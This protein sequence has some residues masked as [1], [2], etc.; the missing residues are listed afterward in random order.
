VDS[1]RPKLGAIQTDD[2]RARRAVAESFVD[3]YRAVL[4]VAVGLAAASSLS[5]AWLIKSTALPDKPATLPGKPVM[6]S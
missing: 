5:T 2:L 6:Q 3:G 1:Q 4:W